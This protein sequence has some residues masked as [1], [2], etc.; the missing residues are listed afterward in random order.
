VSPK[1]IDRLRQHAII[2]A[3]KTAYFTIRQGDVQC[4]EFEVPIIVAA[5]S[6]WEL[7]IQAALVEWI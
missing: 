5:G 2:E 6:L 3:V 1:A 7:Q 4:G